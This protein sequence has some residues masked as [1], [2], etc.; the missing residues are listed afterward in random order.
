MN[1]K[2]F[3]SVETSGLN[4]KSDRIVKIDAIRYDVTTNKHERFTTLVNPGDDFVMPVEATEQNGITIDDINA[5]GIS[6]QAALVKLMEFKDGCDLVGY[7]ILSFDL[8]F[9]AHECERCGVEY[10]VGENIN[11][12][13]TFLVEI[14]R[15]SHKL[16]AVY[17]RAGGSKENATKSEKIAKVFLEQ[18][19][20]VD[21]DVFAKVLAEGRQSKFCVDRCFKVNDDGVIVFAMGQHEGE[22]VADVILKDAGYIRWMCEKMGITTGTKKI[23]K[24]IAE[25]ILKDREK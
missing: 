11:I 18:S 6:T 13:D 15:N 4:P 10:S 2:L 24:Q 9:I 21:K 3:L 23:I 1:N 25:A 7:N 12:C 17:A 5:L 14:E 20:N 8:P 19:N 16:D 22:A